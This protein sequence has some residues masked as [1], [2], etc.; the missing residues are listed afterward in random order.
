[1]AFNFLFLF[2][3][4]K[5]WHQG[6]AGLIELVGEYFDSFTV[7]WKKICK[8]RVLPSFKCLEEFT[9]EGIWAW[10]FLCWSMWIM[11]LLSLTDREIFKFSVLFLRF[12]FVGHVFQIIFN[13]FK[14][15]QL[16]AGSLL[17]YHIFVLLI[18][19]IVYF[20]LIN[21]LFFFPIL[22]LTFS[23]IYYCSNFLRIEK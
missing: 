2:V 23:F 10:S 19:C 16:L 1:M 3:L 13:S 17:K 21:A 20:L 12:T 5:V 18:I 15:S 14:F 8:N 22:F 11:D 7:L 6:G 9:Y 4:D